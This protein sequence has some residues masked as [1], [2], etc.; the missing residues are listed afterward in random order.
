MEWVKV[1]MKVMTINTE[2]LAQQTFQQWVKQVA[3]SRKSSS[4]YSIYLADLQHIVML[5]KRRAQK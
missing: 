3:N 1:L 5:L 4:H 2:K